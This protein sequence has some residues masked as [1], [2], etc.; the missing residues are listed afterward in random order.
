M[1]QTTQQ[2]QNNVLAVAKTIENLDSFDDYIRNKVLETI[3]KT[4]E[5]LNYLGA[6]LLV[7]YGG[8]TIVINTH[9]NTVKGSWGL[10]NYEVLYTNPKLENHLEFKY[11]AKL[12]SLLATNSTR[13]IK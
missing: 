11:N 7:A 13:R 3:Y 9:S 10:D 4:T 6:E 1:N 12:N 8:P 5:S 2:L